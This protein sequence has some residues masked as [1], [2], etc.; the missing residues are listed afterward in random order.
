MPTSNKSKHYAL[1]D[2]GDAV[3]QSEESLAL[4]LTPTT[5]DCSFPI[6]NQQPVKTTNQQ[7]RQQ[8]QQQNPRI[9]LLG[10]KTAATRSGA[11]EWTGGPSVDGGALAADTQSGNQFRYGVK[12]AR[13][14]L[15]Q[16][17]VEP[18]ESTRYTRNSVGAG[19]LPAERAI[20]HHKVVISLRWNSGAGCPVSVSRKLST[21]P[22]L[23]L[24]LLLM[25]VMVMMMMSA[26]TNPLAEA[27]DVI[28]VRSL[29][30][31]FPQMFLVPPPVVAGRLRTTVLVVCFSFFVRDE[32]D[33]SS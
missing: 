22:L 4:S 5:Q 13:A 15:E 16:N 30:L 8:A 23:L 20:H 3:V 19:E 21:P 1:R 17:G 31:R 10:T 27:V 25:M 29:L 24:L 18:F 32:I 26:P 6:A 28:K 33:P 11:L 12:P 2:D 7:R 9:E 14:A